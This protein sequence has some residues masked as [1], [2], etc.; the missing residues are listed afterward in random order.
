MADTQYVRYLGTADEFVDGDVVLE[1]DGAAKA[2]PADRVELLTT[3]PGELFEVLDEDAANETRAAEEKAE[4]DAKAQAEKL[5]KAQAEHDAA[6]QAD[7][8][9]REAVYEAETQVEVDKALEGTETTS[10]PE[11]SPQSP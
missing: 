9:R 8:D 10:V 2:V 5:A 6:A 4:A 7:A 1:K 3:L 11:S